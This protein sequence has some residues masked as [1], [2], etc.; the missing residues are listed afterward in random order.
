MNYFKTAFVATFI[1][2]ATVLAAV[3][4]I[5]ERQPRQ[6]DTLW[7]ESLQQ[8]KHICNLKHHEYRN[9]AEQ[10]RLAEL[11]SLH[12]LATLLRVISSASEVQYQN[13]RKAI[14]SLGGLFHI[15]TT[16]IDH[17]PTGKESLHHAIHH[18]TLHHNTST[19]RSIK[20]ALTDGNRYIARMLTWCDASDVKL[21]MILQRELAADS[22]THSSYRVCPTCSAVSEDS[23]L[24]C[25]C[26]QCMTDSKEFLVFE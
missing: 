17:A 11:D 9:Y 3:Y 25:L 22:L 10:A 12:R 26:P 5:G 23:L 7:R 8:L 13:C 21:I 24:P 15:P 18:K 19:L 14:V 16:I 1:L 4:L 6:S 2:G 20:Q